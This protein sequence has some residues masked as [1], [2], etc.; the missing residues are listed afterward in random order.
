MATWTS[1]VHLSIVNIMYIDSKFIF[2][3]TIITPIFQ[4]LIKSVV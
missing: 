1:Y 3:F 2:L 4:M